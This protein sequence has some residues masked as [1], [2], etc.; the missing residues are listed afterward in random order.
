MSLTEPVAKAVRCDIHAM[1]SCC[2]MSSSES[3]LWR[4]L[5]LNSSN[6][7]SSPFTW[8]A[9]P[10]W[11]ESPPFS[12][13]RSGSGREPGRPY[14]AACPCAT[15]LGSRA[16]FR[17]KHGLRKVSHGKIHVVALIAPRFLERCVH[18]RSPSSVRRRAGGSGT[19]GRL[20]PGISG[21]HPFILQW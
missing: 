7:A 6:N 13:T 2:S 9:Q 14:C 17:R 8:K 3:S 20:T 12:A 21:E 10:S 1:P 4:P 5:A 19:C 16:R 18:L 15:A 11:V